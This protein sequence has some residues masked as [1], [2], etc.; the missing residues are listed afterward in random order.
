LKA[1]SKIINYIITIISYLVPKD[2]KVIV[3]GAFLGNRFGDNSASF[4]NF[5]NVHKENTYKYY[6]LSDSSKVVASIKSKGRNAYLKKSLKGFW[7]TLRASLFITSHG[8]KDVLFY[9]VKRGIVPELYLHHGI[10]LRGSEISTR[11][12]KDTSYK[13]T[14][15]KEIT[16]ML[17]TSVWGGNQQRKNIP[18]EPNKVIVSGYPRNDLFFNYNKDQCESIKSDLGINGYTILY[19]PT[20]RKWGKTIFFPFDDFELDSLVL[21]LRENNITIILRPH[22]VDMY[23]SDDSD[24]VNN[25]DYCNDVIKVISIDEYEDTQKLLLVSDC[26]ITDYSSIF[27]DYLLLE[28]PII[29]FPYDKYIYSKRMGD[30]HGN[31]NDETPGKKIFKQ[32]IFIDYISEIKN[33]KDEFCEARYNLCKLSHKYADGNSSKRL[34]NLIDELMN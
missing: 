5:C 14:R 23:R 21:F 28:R 34:F 24:L 31:Y 17:A 7:L 13:T 12:L 33:G 1:I 22:S 4:F 30:F 9:S 26:L 19:A 8:L 6:W 16:Y 20:W 27:Y 29:F 11:G 3:F 25:I 18:V 15:P 32:N 10:P 2:R